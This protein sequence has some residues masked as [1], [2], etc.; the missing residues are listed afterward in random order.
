MRPE[1]SACLDMMADGISGRLRDLLLAR[2]RWEGFVH[3]PGEA[4]AASP[5]ASPGEAER[6]AAEQV[7]RTLRA[8]VEVVNQR[9][10]VR[11]LGDAERT[12]S[13]GA[14]TELTGLPRIP[15]TE[16]VHDLAQVGLV[17]YSPDSPR[18][19]ATALAAGLLGLLDELRDRLVRIMGERH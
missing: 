3:E 1:P 5:A 19:Q 18:V 7:L 13:L 11:L 15:L 4:S 9:I 2:E 16:R 6:V 10:L 14:L 12:V 8:A 17:S